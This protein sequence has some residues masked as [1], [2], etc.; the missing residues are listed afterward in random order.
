MSGKVI[1]V[2]VLFV[3]LTVNALVLYDLGKSEF[4]LPA[5]EDRGFDRVEAFYPVD[6]QIDFLNVFLDKERRT[7]VLRLKAGKGNKLRAVGTIDK[8]GKLGHGVNSVGKKIIIIVD[9]EYLH[10][11]TFLYIICKNDAAFGSSE[12]SSGSLAI[13]S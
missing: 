12:S 1:A 3:V 10:N 11:R 5:R 8:I 2:M 7:A 4:V 6:V 9:I 13:I